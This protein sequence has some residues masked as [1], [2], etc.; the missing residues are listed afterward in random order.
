MIKRQAAIVT[1]RVKAENIETN[2]KFFPSFIICIKLS[3][4]I[5]VGNSHQRIITQKFTLPIDDNR[6]VKRF[7]F[8]SRHKLIKRTIKLKQ[9]RK[10]I[11][12]SRKATMIFHL[13]V[14]MFLVNCV[15]SAG[16]SESRKSREDDGNST[17]TEVS[18]LFVATTQRILAKA[19]STY[20]R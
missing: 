19:S 11:M 4:V 17:A 14:T 8:I 9:L 2:I 15:T 7:A 12:Y 16:S 1:T 10:A 3:F 20:E 5:F 6:A 13:L 18:N